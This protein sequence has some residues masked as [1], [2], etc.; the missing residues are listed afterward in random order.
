MGDFWSPHVRG[1]MGNLKSKRGL[2]GS[3]V[4]AVIR[5]IV[6]N[7][8]P[9]CVFRCQVKEIGPTNCSRNFEKTLLADFKNSGGLPNDGLSS[10]TNRPQRI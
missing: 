10:Q 5:Q 8:S 6:E 7:C 1:C 2:E 4:S 9:V 3:I